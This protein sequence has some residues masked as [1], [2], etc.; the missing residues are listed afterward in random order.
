[1]NSCLDRTRTIAIKYGFGVNI[2][3][4][5]YI[6]LPQNL[7]IQY[8][9]RLSKLMVIAAITYIIQ[10]YKYFPVTVMGN[11]IYSYT[12]MRLLDHHKIGFIGCHGTNRI[13]Y[14]ETADG[15]EIAFEGSRP[16]AFDYTKIN[17]PVLSSDDIIKLQN[18]TGLRNLESIQSTYW[19][20]FDSNIIPKISSG[21]VI[22]IKKFIG[23]IYYVR[24]NDD[25]WLTHYIINDAVE[26]IRGGD[27]IVG[28]K[29]IPENIFNPFDSQLIITDLYGTKNDLSI[30][31]L[32]PTIQSESAV[33]GLKVPRPYMKGIAHP[34]HLPM[35]SDMLS[36]I[37]IVT[38]HSII[39]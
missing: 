27:I 13:S 22:E 15:C 14:Y 23:D 4:G 32:D 6:V 39:H 5:R 26:P 11:T 1:M 20:Y 31:C 36:A 29:Y 17:P 24:T 38:L 2:S 34:F 8:A 25:T 37:C 7:Y 19:P 3:G 28:Y 35:V 9:M 18:H 16:S 33:Y 30:V 12:I 10:K 21:P